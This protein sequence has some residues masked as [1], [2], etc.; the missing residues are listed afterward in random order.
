MSASHK[1]KQKPLSDYAARE[2]QDYYRSRNDLLVTFQIEDPEFKKRLKQAA[3]ADNRSVNSWI[4]KYI[5]PVMEE[6]IEA[7]EGKKPKGR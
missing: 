1:P 6:E 7:Q 4:N 3:Q 2:R 5:L